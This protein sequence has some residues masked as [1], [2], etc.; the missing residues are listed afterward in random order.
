MRGA[1]LACRTLLKPCCSHHASMLELPW[2]HNAVAGAPD[3]LL[4]EQFQRGSS[5]VFCGTWHTTHGRPRSPEYPPYGPLIG[6]SHRHFPVFHALEKLRNA[7][8]LA[9]STQLISL[10]A[11]IG[12]CDFRCVTR[13]LV[14]E[15]AAE[16]GISAREK[17]VSLSELHCADEVFTTGTMGEVSFSTTLQTSM[18]IPGFSPVSP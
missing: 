5:A 1:S 4:R 3:E 18:E 8:G 6:S 10:R 2:R 9:C 17:R 11:D 14:L 7:L 12:C 13:G 16:L 15:L